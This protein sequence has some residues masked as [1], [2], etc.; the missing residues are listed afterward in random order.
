MCGLGLYG[1]AS[2]IDDVCVGMQTVNFVR[3][4]SLIVAYFDSMANIRK[5]MIYAFE[6]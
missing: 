3:F 6:I 5:E 2:W 4:F 1:M